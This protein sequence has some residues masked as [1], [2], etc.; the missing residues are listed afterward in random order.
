VESSAN[1][2]TTCN[3]KRNIEIRQQIGTVTMVIAWFRDYSLSWFQA[4]WAGVQLLVLFWGTVLH[5]ETDHCRVGGWKG[6]LHNS[7]KIRYKFSKNWANTRSLVNTV[8]VYTKRPSHHTLPLLTGVWA[9]I[10]LHHE[11]IKSV[12]YLISGM[13][14]KSPQSLLFHPQ[15]PLSWQHNGYTTVSE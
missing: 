14:W 15:Q 10:Q 12:P 1:L 6:L 8:H 7:I 13:L 3:K 9:N 11:L 2:S 4:G 5:V